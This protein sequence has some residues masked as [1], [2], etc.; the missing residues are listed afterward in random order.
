VPVTGGFA[1][2]PEYL[3]YDA[4]SVLNM[5]TGVK[6]NIG[7][8]FYNLSA[9]RMDWDDPQLNIATPNWGFYAAVNGE[10]ARSQGIEFELRG[11]LTQD[12]QY[13]FG[14]SYVNA[15]LTD[16][17]VVPSGTQENPSSYVYAEKGERLP[18]MADHTLTGGLSHTAVLPHGLYLVSN[19]NAYYQSE[20]RNALGDDPAFAID[21][22]AFWLANLSTTVQA[23][24]WS[25]TLF[26][27]NI[28]NEEGVTGVLSESYMGTDPDENFYGNGSKQYITQPRTVGVG[29][30]YRF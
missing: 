25:V 11:Y 21:L 2:N 1:E 8:H 20:S 30:S 16:D 27:R 7:R 29:V 23:E 26:A 18:S 19:F 17:L 12:L 15:E 9:F 22:D 24:D 6:G 4:D 3:S 13:N 5:E 10:S 28:F 14:Y